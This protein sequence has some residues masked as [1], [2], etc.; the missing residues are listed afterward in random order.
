MK[1]KSDKLTYMKELVPVLNYIN[2]SAKYTRCNNKQV[3]ML[4]RDCVYVY[5]SISS[6]D[7]RK[8]SLCKGN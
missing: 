8:K 1:Q 6:A 5:V 7:C 2:S 4:S 3:F